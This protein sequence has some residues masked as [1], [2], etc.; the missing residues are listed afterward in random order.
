MPNKIL[1]SCPKK[2]EKG[3]EKK[4]DIGLLYPYCFPF[5]EVV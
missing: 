4:Q 1:C 2:I 5:E 3:V